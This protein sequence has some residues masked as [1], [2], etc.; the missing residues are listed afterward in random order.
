MTSNDMDKSCWFCGQH[1]S[2]GMGTDH[3]VWIRAPA[4]YQGGSQETVWD[5]RGITVE[6]CETCRNRH[7]MLRIVSKAA[8]SLAGLGLLAYVF[9]DDQWYTSA[10]VFYVAI[11]LGVAAITT[12]ILFSRFQRALGTRPESAEKKHPEVRNY[13]SRGAQLGRAPGS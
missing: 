9:W 11:A 13:L 10:T 5:E 1:P 7:G 12:R 4:D 3:V 8:W 6:R 2:G